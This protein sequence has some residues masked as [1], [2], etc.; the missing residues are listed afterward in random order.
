[1]A[2]AAALLAAAPVTAR[3]QDEDADD[4]TRRAQARE[5]WYNDIY[6]TRHQGRGKKGGPWSPQYR[7]FI[8]EAAARERAKWGALIPS[9]SEGA[10]V[11][12]PSA[13]V[14]ATGTT[15]TNLGPTKAD[16][17]KNGSYTLQ[18]TDTGRVRNFVT[19]P[20]NPD[21]LYVA[22]S[23]GGVWKT[24]DGGA[25]WAALTESL[26]SLSVGSLA[27]D[28]SDATASTL[29]LGLGDPFD[30]TGIGL[31]K[32]T[33]GGATW[34]APVYLGTSRVTT[35]VMVAPG[36]S[37]IVLATTDQGLFR[38]TDGG[39]TFSNVA[40]ATGQTGAPYAWSIAWTGGSNFVMSLEAN[41]LAASGTT[42]GQVWTSSNDG[43]TWTRATGF[44][45]SGGVDRITVAS[46][47][48][49]R[50]IVYAVAANPSGNL[51]DFFKS[52]NGGQS[53]TAL[54]ATAKGVRY[55][56]SNQ[57]AS[58]PASLFNTQGWYDQMVLVHP[59]D[60]NIVDFGGALHNARTT[61]GGTS[62]SMTTEWLGRY[63]LPYVHADTHAAAYDSV[64]HLYFGTDGGIFKSTNGGA[65]FSDAYNV[66]IASHLVYNLGS[67]TT[68]PS[69]V[70]GGFQDN[71]TRVR[72]GSTSTFNQT[73]GG[74]G[75][76]C[77][78]NATNGNQMLGSLYYTDIRK[79]TDGGLTFASA[80]S[81]LRECGNGNYSPFYTRIVSWGGDPT[82]NT[83][84]TSTNTKIYKS[85][86]YA[87]SWSAPRRSAGL[88]SDLAIR[89]FNVATSNA[90]VMGIAG[91][92]GRFYLS[93]NG[94]ANWTA[95]PTTALP[96]NELSLSYV[97]FASNDANIVYLASV[98]P[99]STAAHL[100][101]STNFGGTWTRIDTAASGFPE[102]VPVDVVKNDPGDP[103]VI[104]A[105]TH[106]GVYRSLD[107]GATWA[108]F[109][110]GMPLVEITDLYL[111]SD[112]SLVRASTF[113][114]GFWELLP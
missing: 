58:G 31:V 100:W 86:N 14:V 49:N 57:T 17:L 19:H 107:G 52:T 113:G 30:G 91:T 110:A 81:G 105:G 3:A 60:A 6:A 106:L 8:M 10:T 108:R 40:I 26:G 96:N 11:V 102:G 78:V 25:S 39:A 5:E 68:T 67:S 53:W 12:D 22:F 89:N 13:T 76:G 43:A 74:D 36:N 99:S 64:G 41:P 28:P 109:G 111:S 83:V 87:G 70:L 63:S 1:M 104:Y 94:G 112:S 20:S 80:C 18:V 2:I 16:Y 103:N 55:T 34:S 97:W 37:S 95:V 69:A 59:T 56:N 7:R 32:S 48:S 75:F 47:P 62:W 101:K 79:S 90:N 88:A 50:Q 33:D 44:T 73:I 54:N 98:A 66:G 92:G 51:A 9:N 29:Y 27:A 38:S 77:D 24:T 85:T 45:K 114:R 15:W 35:Q 21:V 4:A 82:G 72:A 84:F 65:S 23:G 42:D 46:A 93:T 61:T 71:G